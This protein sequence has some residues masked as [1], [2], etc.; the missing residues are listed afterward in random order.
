MSDP[1]DIEVL[2]A[3]EHKSWSGWMRYLTPIL[4]AQFTA[5]DRDDHCS[6]FKNGTG[7][8]YGREF[9]CCASV[10]HEGDHEFVDSRVAALRSLDCF[11]RWTRQMKTDYVDLSEKEQ[12]SDR[13][14]ARKKLAVYRLPS[15]V[16]VGGLMG[17]ASSQKTRERVVC[18]TCKGQGRIRHPFKGLVEDCRMCK[19]RRIAFRVILYE[20][21]P[22][23]DLEK[24]YYYTP[25]GL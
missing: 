24:S 4:E 11:K 2:A 14:E 25:K 20:E 22:E 3:E 13:S 17:Y 21:I 23:S 7:D 8:A 6:A 1:S 10:G 18:P 16:G 5:Y 9:P 12:E 15:D 19:G